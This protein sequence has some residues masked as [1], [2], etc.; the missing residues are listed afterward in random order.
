MDELTNDCNKITHIDDLKVE[1]MEH[2]KT[3]IYAMIEFEKNNKFIYDIDN[4]KYPKQYG[5]YPKN[6]T[7]KQ[8]EIE[9]TIG[10]L[11][12]KVGSGKSYMIV[13]FIKLQPTAPTRHQMYIGTPYFNAKLIYSKPIK[14]NLVIVPHKLILQWTDFFKWAP[15]MKI[16]S[17][18]SE[19]NIKELSKENIEKYDVV[20]LSNTKIKSFNDKYSDIV[21]SRIFID[22]A[23]TI[24]FDKDDFLKASFIWFIT[25]TP[26]AL[27][28]TKK[29]LLSHIFTTLPRANIDFITIKNNNDFIEN[30]VNLLPPT[31]VIIPCLTPSEL[32]IIWDFVPKSIITMI[33]A[34]NIDDAIRT[35]NCNVDT[36]EN[37]FQVITHQLETLIKD[38]KEE[39]KHELKKKVQKS[40]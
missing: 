6:L 4:F 24:G 34:G 27:K 26:N 30:S 3:A 39:I 13:S 23:H 38:K 22:E 32:K 18:N 16:V 35:L 12:D 8:L 25:A 15:S 14:T 10:V 5:S 1:L 2:Q 20:L 37:I 29:S 31:R 9:S 11:A 33:N 17:V 36:K 7:N 28:Y 21:W 19:K 40:D